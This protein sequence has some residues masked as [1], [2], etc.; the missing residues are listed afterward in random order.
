MNVVGST[1]RSGSGAGRRTVHTANRR[2]F[3]VGWPSE[4]PLG[5]SYEY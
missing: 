2:V 1:E 5:S 3:V 4:S